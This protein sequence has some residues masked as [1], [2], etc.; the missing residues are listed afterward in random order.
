LSLV[1]AMYALPSLVAWPVAPIKVQAC[2]T[3]TKAELVKSVDI[4]AHAI[5]LLILIVF[6][7]CSGRPNN[8]R[9]TYLRPAGMVGRRFVSPVGEIL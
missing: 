1:E 4:R 3:P 5:V 8:G 2:A 9:Q 6:L 7:P